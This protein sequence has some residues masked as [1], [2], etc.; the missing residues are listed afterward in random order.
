MQIEKDKSFMLLAW[1]LKSVVYL[2]AC[3]LFD[4]LTN[5][6]LLGY[7][8]KSWLVFTVQAQEVTSLLVY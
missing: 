3:S 7:K 2:L 6:C 4:E 5:C 1:W 8:V